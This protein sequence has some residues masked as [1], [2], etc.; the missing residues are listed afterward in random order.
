MNRL[1]CGYS[2]RAGFLFWLCG[3]IEA[4]QGHAADFLVRHIRVQ[5]NRVPVQLVHVVSRNY[6]LKQLAQQIC[7]LWIALE[8]YNVPS[9]MKHHESKPFPAQ[10][11]TCNI[12]FK[13]AVEGLVNRSARNTPAEV[14]KFVFVHGL[15]LS[16]VAEEADCPA[17]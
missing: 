7:L 16:D 6:A 1:S 5:N 10:G 4:V 9:I 12:A 8:I 14:Q 13:V 2:G 11:M 15:F 3:E 17:F